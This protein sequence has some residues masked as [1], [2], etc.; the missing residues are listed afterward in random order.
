GPYGSASLRS[1]RRPCPRGGA[2]AVPDDNGLYMAE[3][4]PGA[5]YV[6]L[7]GDDHLPWVGNADAIL[8]EVEEFLTGTRRGPEPDRVLA[9]VMFTDIVGATTKATELG[10]RQWRNLL[11]AHHALVREHLAKFRGREID[12]AGDGFLAAFD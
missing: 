4:I 7:R 3:A 8:D 5:K 1:P 2:G 12:T 10:D 9:T 11:D 6:E